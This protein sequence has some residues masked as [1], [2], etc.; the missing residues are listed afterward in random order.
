[1]VL[2]PIPQSLPVHFFGSRPQPPTSR[3]AQYSCAFSWVII[4]FLEYLTHMLAVIHLDVFA[5]VFSTHVCIAQVYI[6]M[7]LV[8]YLNICPCVWRHSSSVRVT[9]LMWGWERVLWY[10]FCG[11]CSVEWSWRAVYTHEYWAIHTWILTSSRT[12]S[13]ECSSCWGSVRNKSF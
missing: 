1:M 10:M 3:V 5:S 2:D 12:C 7:C 13:V 8:Q 11:M 9:R 4:H 6:H